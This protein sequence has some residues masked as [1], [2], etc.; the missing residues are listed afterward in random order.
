M[1]E[2]LDCVSA[3]VAA[4]SQGEVADFLKDVRPWVYRLALAIVGRPDVAE[5]VAQESL[6]RCWSACDSLRAA[7]D[8]RAWTRKVVVRQAINRLKTV[9]ESSSTEDVTNPEDQILVRMVLETMP[10]ADRA[11]L[12]LTYFE[13]LSYAEMAESLG[14]P[15]GTV[16]SRLSK[17]K[18][19]FRERW[20]DR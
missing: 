14:I 5:D 8:M 7:N 11:L 13:Q 19:A 3:R 12:A 1:V 2:R 9:R 15:E 16:A 17:A 4:R 6:V 20:G 10:P 18:Q